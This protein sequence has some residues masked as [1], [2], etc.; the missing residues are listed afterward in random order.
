[1]FKPIHLQFGKF[2]IVG[3]INTVINY[4]VFIVLFL[5]FNLVYFLAGV[6]GFLSGGVSGFVLNRL[7]TFK[8]KVPFA[9]GFK[10]YFIIQFFCLG[11]HIITQ[12]SA[13]SIFGV[14]EIFSQFAGIFVTT[15][16]NFFLIRE[17]VFKK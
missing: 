3:V 4:G 2:I 8:S 14:P 9:T 17:V 12:I 16:L 13:T 6:I 1:M 7:W 10:K 5:V 15:F 11:A